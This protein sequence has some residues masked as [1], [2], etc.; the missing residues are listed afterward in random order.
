MILVT[1]VISTYTMVRN[2]PLQDS[3]KV[4]T[5]IG[6]MNKDIKTILDFTVGYYGSILKVTGNST[7]AKGLTTSYLSSGLVNIARS[8]P[9]W[10]PSFT[11]NSQQVS[12]RW[13]MPES[14][15][16]GNI[17][18][19]YSLAALGIEGVKYETSSALQVKMLE[20]DLGVAQIRVTRDNTE[21]ELGLSEENFWFYKYN[22]DDS[23]WDASQSRLTSQFLLMEFIT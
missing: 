20:S 7:Y 17:S 18:V 22:Y 10:N 14:Y 8:H 4:L 12:T 23:T 21:P 2:A 19:T 9:E 11:L 15:S 16:M 3:P 13:F 6:E 1:A 5:A